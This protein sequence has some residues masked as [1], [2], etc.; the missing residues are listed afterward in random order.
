MKKVNIKTISKMAGVSPAAVSF[1]L[2]NKG[3]VS[4]ETRKRILDVVEREGY[5]PNINSRRLSMKRSFNLAIIMNE[6]YS[7]FTDAF[8]SD[9][10]YS[11][12]KRA[13][14]LNYQMLMLPV[15]NIDNQESLSISVRQGNIDGAIV[16]HDLDA[17][18]FARLSDN[19]IPMVAID[20]HMADPIYPC[21]K[22]DYEKG[23]Y[24]CTE[25]LINKGHSN[26]GYIGIGAL[27][28]FYL[29]CQ[30][31]YMG[32]LAT[33]K[34]PIHPDWI[35]CVDVSGCPLQEASRQIVAKRIS[36]DNC[37]SA[38]FCGND[39]VAIG[40]INALADKGI[41]VPE[42]VSIISMDDISMARFFIP[43]LTTLHVNADAMGVKAVDL[44]NDIIQKNEHKDVI[45]EELGPIIERD[46]V[47]D[48]L[49]N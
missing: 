12:V 37:P 47:R 3:G 34:L 32:A 25:Y 44:L 14:E 33:A 13:A 4:E 6:T 16:M 1:V 41:R 5:I 21:I 17:L 39:L 22:V 8:A 38:F 11:A 29:S 18:S 48:L 19:G 20:S 36:K 2:N 31:G 49:S 7:L 24:Q 40:T 28:D 30:K 27:P 26:I 35:V 46:S 45:F 15:M 10:M 42:D 23:A 9:S 43:S